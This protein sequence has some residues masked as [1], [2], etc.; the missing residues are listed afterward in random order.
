[1]SL[2]LQ[3]A[4]QKVGGRKMTNK[5]ALEKVEGYLTSCL[6][7]GDYSEVE[8]IMAALEPE[9]SEDCISRQAVNELQ[10]YRYNCGD[11]AIM[12]VS[13]NSIN[14]LPPVTPQPKIGH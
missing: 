5:E 12:C 4:K 9:P 7:I 8:E 2:I 10:K 1:M 14:N 6:P 11:K 3:S 13:L